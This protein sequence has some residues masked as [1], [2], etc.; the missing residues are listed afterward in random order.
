[1]SS[2]DPITLELIRCRLVSGAQQMAAALWKSSYSTVIRE[3]LDYSTALFDARGRMVAQS[4]AIPFQMMTMSDPMRYLIETDYDWQEG[5]V[6]L[7]NDP[8]VCHGQHL[9][10][11]MTFRPIFAAG[12]PIAF[13]GAIGH[14]I[15]T[16]G[17]ASGS[18]LA[19]ATEIYQEGLRIPPVKI[20]RAGSRNQE[21]LDLIALNVREPEKLMGDLSAMIACTDMG[22]LAV[23]ELCRRYGVETLQQAHEEIIGRSAQQLRNRIAELPNGTYHAVGFVDD[24]GITDDPIRLEVHFTIDGDSIHADFSGTSPQVQGPVNANLEMTM[25]TVLYCVM[26]TIGQGIAKTDGFRDVIHVDAPLRTVLNAQSPAPVVSRVTTCHRLVDVILEALAQVIPD[27]VTAG[28]YGVS[29]ICNIGGYDPATGKSWVH[30]EIEVGGWGARPDS[31]GL[32]G[33]SAHIHNVAN[34]PIEVVETTVPVRVERY[35]FI[36]DSGGKGKYRGGL[37]LRRDFRVMQ[38]DATL[39]L[40]GDHAKFPPRGMRGGGDGATGRYVLNPETPEERVMP[41]KLS[42]YPLQNGD[43]ISMQTPGGGGYGEPAERDPQNEER[44]RREG[45]VD[46]RP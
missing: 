35:E 19:T 43:V 46:G 16:G 7:L 4:A 38:P 30:F 26:A 12:R 20:L 18:Y 3:V 36:A 37:G 27:R 23:E 45:K 25:A 40:L 33:F 13:A 32:D 2:I 31:D 11:Y 28:Y 8:F 5:D 29:N 24:D 41:N 1:M 42:N 44:D 10:D 21:L 34:T 17:G 15:D 22:R 14:M 9:P 39:N 6:V